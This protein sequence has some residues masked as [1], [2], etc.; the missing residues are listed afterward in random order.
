MR[1]PKNQVYSAVEIRHEGLTLKKT[2]KV[3]SNAFKIVVKSISSIYRWCKKFAR[4][5][6]E[7]IQGLG[8]LLETDETEIE[9]YD[10]EKAWFWGVKC[11]K[12]KKLV[13]THVSKTRTLKDAKL[14]FWEAR[15]RFPLPIG[16]SLSEQTVGMDTEEQSLKFSGMELSMTNS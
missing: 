2:R 3:V 13:A 8:G 6:K 5:D 11:V 4:D 16:Q 15:R 1:F 14:L 10:G 9:L 7:V 12:T